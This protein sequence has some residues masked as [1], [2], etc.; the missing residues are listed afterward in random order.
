MVDSQRYGMVYKEV[1]N[2]AGKTLKWVVCLRDWGVLSDDDDMD[3][4]SNVNGTYLW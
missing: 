3:D 2:N 1:K 4:E